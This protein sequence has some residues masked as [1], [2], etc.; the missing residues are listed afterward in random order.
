V[1]LGSAGGHFSRGFNAPNRVVVGQ[2]LRPGQQFTVAVFAANGPMSN[3]PA[4]Y[5]W[6]RSATLDFYKPGRIGNAHEVVT[7]I[8]R[9]F[10]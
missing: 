3:P 7:Q 6:I 10:C 2:D 5:I 4:N 8:E 9:Y 1:V